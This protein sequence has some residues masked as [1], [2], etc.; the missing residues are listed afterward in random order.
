MSSIKFQFPLRYHVINLTIGHDLVISVASITMKIRFMQRCNFRGRGPLYAFLERVEYH[1]ENFRS[2]AKSHRW[3]SVGLN[4]WN[5]KAF[6]ANWGCLPSFA[7]F[8]TKPP[9]CNSSQFLHHIFYFTT[10]PLSCYLSRYLTSGIVHVLDLEGPGRVT[11]VE[12][13]QYIEYNRLLYQIF[14]FLG[15]KLVDEDYLLWRGRQTDFSLTFLM[16]ILTSDN[17]FYYL[18]LSIFSIVLWVNWQQIRANRLN[19]EYIFIQE[20]L[21]KFLLQQVR[22]YGGSWGV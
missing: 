1:T 10:P 17:Q 12:S 22:N 6:S 8:I 7:E 3:N 16:Y 19:Y 4:R 5:T 11:T 21:R 13:I 2:F 18:I 14:V 15:A 9:F 20:K